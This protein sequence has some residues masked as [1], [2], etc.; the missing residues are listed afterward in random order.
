M[1]ILEILKTISEISA[2]QTRIPNQISAISA[3]SRSQNPRSLK[4]RFP[5]FLQVRFWTV[6]IHRRRLRF[7]L[8]SLPRLH[9]RKKRRNRKRTIRLQACFD[10]QRF[11]CMIFDLVFYTRIQTH[12][13]CVF[14]KSS[15]NT[16]TR[17]APLQNLNLQVYKTITF[18]NLGYL[19]SS[20]K[21][22]FTILNSLT[23]L[24]C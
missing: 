4:H 20:V 2:R 15:T 18:I 1:M 13:V 6:L 16:S 24:T 7:R 9:L 21:N 10:D 5:K 3:I 14:V 8:R 17:F 22:W 19:K 11:I 23:Q 12:L